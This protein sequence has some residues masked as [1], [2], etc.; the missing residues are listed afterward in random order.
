[1]C[2]RHVAMQRRAC[3]FKREREWERGSVSEE[4]SESV[5]VCVL[6]ERKKIRN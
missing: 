1:M 4:E 6:M 5:C 3:A 2:H